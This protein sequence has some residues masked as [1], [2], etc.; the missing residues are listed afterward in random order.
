M[1]KHSLIFAVSL[2]VLLAVM[3]SANYK[4]PEF[5]DMEVLTDRDMDS[6]MTQSGVAIWVVTF[7]VPWCQH[8]HK[9]APLLDQVKTEFTE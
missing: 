3:S 8:T 7:Y 4:E 1:R 5:G 6:K 2:L 9:I